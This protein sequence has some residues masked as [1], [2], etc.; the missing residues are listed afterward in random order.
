MLERG[1]KVADSKSQKLQKLKQSVREFSLFDE[2]IN[3]GVLYALDLLDQG[4]KEIDQYC[5]QIQVSLTTLSSTSE[6]DSR[7]VYQYLKK[8]YDD[9][10]RLTSAAMIF[11][12]V[13]QTCSILDNSIREV[14]SMLQNLVKLS[15]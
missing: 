13:T 9:N 10:A 2:P 5:E 8:A 14:E 15:E 12:S 4:K 11:G 6:L 3:E 7:T 1:S